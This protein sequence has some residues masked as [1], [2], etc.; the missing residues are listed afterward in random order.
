MTLPPP[1]QSLEVV[2]FFLAE[3][4]ANTPMTSAAAAARLKM[5]DICVTPL[6]N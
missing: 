6:C 2:G 1:G 4:V 5:S 3:A